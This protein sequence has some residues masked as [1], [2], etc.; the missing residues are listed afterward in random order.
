MITLYH[1]LSDKKLQRLQECH[2]LHPTAPFNADV[3]EEQWSVYAAR[4][5]FPVSPLNTFCFLERNPPSWHGAGLFQ[6]LM[7]E[8]AG[9]EHLLQLNIY[10]DPDKPILVRDHYFHSPCSY[11]FSP[12]EWKKRPVRSSR[13]DLKEQWYDSAILLAQ[14]P[15]NYVC[16][17]IL[18]P[19]PISEQQTRVIWSR[20][21]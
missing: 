13:P 15:N 3:P 8:Y 21:I 2:S 4:F 11:G 16:P 5:P 10:D 19:F 20:N 6:L 17:E 7:E 18:V 9:G 1:Y 12:D 14:Y